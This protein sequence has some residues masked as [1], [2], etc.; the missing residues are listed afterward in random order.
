MSHRIKNKTGC[1]I[2]FEGIDGSGKTTQIRRLA[3]A[4]S[5]KRRKVVLTREPGGSPAAERIRRMILDTRGR[6]LPPHAELLLYMAARARHVNEIILPALKKGA[7][8]LCDRFSDATAAYQGGGRGLPL[9]LIEDL[10]RAA[11]R[12]LRPALTLLMDLPAQKALARIRAS[13]KKADRME[14]EGRAFL[15][16]VRGT[17]LRLAAKAPRRVRIIDAAGPAGAVQK[18]ITRLWNRKFPGLK[19][20]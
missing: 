14:K 5:K 3:R 10:N 16:K 9:R 6:G 18:E 2:T 4:L 20:Q 7:I 8:V 15:E 11:C 17:Y 12:G 13:G 19:I 1:F